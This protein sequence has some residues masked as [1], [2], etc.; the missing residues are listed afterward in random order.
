[1]PHQAFDQLG[2][3]LIEPDRLDRL[4]CN[5][6]AAR[7]VVDTSVWQ[8]ADVVE[9]A[10]EQQDVGPID[11]SQVRLCLGYCLH[12]VAVHRVPMDRIVLGTSADRLPR[13]NPSA[14][15]SGEVEGFP[16]R[17]HVWPGGQHVQ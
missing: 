4:T 7:G 14:Y 9:K 16:D 10:G 1:M 13:R 3:A 15:T 2:V 5:R 11:T 17:H 12:Q 6:R 8:L